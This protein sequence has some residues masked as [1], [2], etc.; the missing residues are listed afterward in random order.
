MAP[1][2]SAVATPPLHPSPPRAVSPAGETD[3]SHAEAPRSVQQAAELHP[4]PEAA[5]GGDNE[6]CDTSRLPPGRGGRKTRDSRPAASPPPLGLPTEDT[7][8]R[9]AA[10]QVLVVAPWDWTAASPGPRQGQRA[11][12]PQRQVRAGLRATGHFKEGLWGQGALQRQTWPKLLGTGG[13]H[14]N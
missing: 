9:P 7:G 1:W 14:E 13:G 11:P 5:C 2:R 3:A 6:A 8:A 10:A 12:G 4:G